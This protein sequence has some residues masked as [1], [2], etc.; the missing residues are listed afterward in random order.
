MTTE[1]DAEHDRYSLK[2]ELGRSEVP[3]SYLSS[4]LRVLQATLREVGRD[5]ERTRPQFEE[6][7][8]P[9]LMA[10]TRGD[11]ALSAALFFSDSPDGPP[12]E[13]LS[14]RVFDAFMDRFADYVSGLPQPSLFG[15][16][17]PGSS[18]RSNDTPVSRRMSQVHRELRRAGKVSVH[19]DKRAV[20]IDGESMEIT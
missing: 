8:S 4:L 2:V 10:T 12:M 9:V 16:A 19:V 11:D 7:P 14:R 3:V 1:S 6:R 17:A 18:G 13:E 5:D 15:G 20:R